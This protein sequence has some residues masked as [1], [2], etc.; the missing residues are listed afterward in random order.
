MAG[1]DGVQVP[2]A[3]AESHAYWVIP[4]LAPDPDALTRRL[5]GHGFYATR[6]RAFAVVEQDPGISAPA[7]VG[8]EE[9]HAS[10]VYLP[11]GPEM[12]GPVLDEL[13]RIVR[14]ELA[15]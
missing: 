2:T 6:G 12:P 15:A 14:D 13:A 3:E 7:P 10:S 11:F 1:L 5:A 8:A 9:L 4:V